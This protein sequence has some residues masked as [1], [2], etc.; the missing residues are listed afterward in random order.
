MVIKKSEKHVNYQK[1]CK[2]IGVVILQ[3]KVGGHILDNGCETTIS[4]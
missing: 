2:I 1:T 4:S 3:N